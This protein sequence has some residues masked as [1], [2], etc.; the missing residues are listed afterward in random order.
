MSKWLNLAMTLT[1]VGKLENFLRLSYSEYPNY[2]IFYL[3]LNKKHCIS[4][5][6]A[7]IELS[8]IIYFDF[9]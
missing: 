3:F 5:Q 4:F 6:N 2:A 1:K 9:F 7:G 8:V